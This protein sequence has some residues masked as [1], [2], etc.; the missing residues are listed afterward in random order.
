MKNILIFFLLLVGCTSTVVN[1]S[2]SNDEPS[3]LAKKIDVK[4]FDSSLKSQSLYA[5]LNGLKQDTQLVEWSFNDCGEQSG[6]ADDVGRDFPKC[7]DGS[8]LSRKYRILR[9]VQVFVGT[10]KKG[11]F[12]EPT[13]R[14]IYSINKDESFTCFDSLRDLNN[15]INDNKN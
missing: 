7:L 15:L 5:W 10:W 14:F 11:V 12:G 13:M 9:G 1:R 2:E 6:T 3:Q 4:R 8:I